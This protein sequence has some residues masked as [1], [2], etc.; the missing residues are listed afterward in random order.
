MSHHSSR[1]ATIDGP[2]IALSGLCL[3]HCLFLPVLSAILPIA[4]TLGEAEWLHK[5]FI[6]AALPFTLMALRSKQTRPAT[7]LRIVIENGLLATVAFVEAL[8]DFEKQLTVAG[9]LKLALGHALRW[10]AG[11]RQA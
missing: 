7:G 2:A 3:I 5:A 1:A 11:S 4:G 9:A 10:S 8:N 6:V